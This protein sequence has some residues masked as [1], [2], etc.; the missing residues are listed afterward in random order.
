MKILV[1]GGLGY[2][3]AHT[4]T[5]LQNSGFEVIVIDNL[6]NSSEAVLEGI[7]AITGVTPVF[8]NLDLRKKERVAAFFRNHNDI[9]GVIHFAAFKAVGES[10]KKP[11]LYY[12]N[13]INAL[14]YLLRELLKH[15]IHRFIFSSSCTVY[16]TA[17]RLPLTEDSPL[18]PPTSPYGSTKQTGERIISDSCAAAPDFKAIALRYFNPVGAHE[19]ARIGESPLGEPQNLVPVIIRTALGLQ[20]QFSVFGNDYPTA[21]G[22]CIRD[23]I[24]VTDVAKAH[25]MALKR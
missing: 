5:E 10:V 2:V 23:Y 25:V 16:G 11:L 20:T 19:S 21:D 17:D 12:E 8:E 14:V 18:N 13:N 6:S 9:T 22:T 7:T 3:G 15:N 4:V 1:T 24:H